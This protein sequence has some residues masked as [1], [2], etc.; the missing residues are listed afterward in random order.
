MIPEEILLAAKQATE[1]LLPTKSKD[2]YEKEYIIFKQWM[3][4][5]EVNVI[6]EDV[7]FLKR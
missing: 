2:R 5:K 6:N 7:L 3:Q 1:N 4:S